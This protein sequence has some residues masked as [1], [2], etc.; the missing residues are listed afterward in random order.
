M[1]GKGC[2]AKFS[3]VLVLISEKILS[4]LFKLMLDPI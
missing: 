3:L 2:Y 1:N 4:D